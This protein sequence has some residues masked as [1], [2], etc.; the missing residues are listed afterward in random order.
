MSYV[1]LESN[2]EKYKFLKVH[3]CCQIVCFI[4]KKIHNFKSYE[5]MLTFSSLIFYVI[6]YNFFLNNI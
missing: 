5:N 6:S 1:F 4:L 2:L 3:N